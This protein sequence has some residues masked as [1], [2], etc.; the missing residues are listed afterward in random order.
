MLSSMPVIS[1][2]L[3]L[4]RRENR[5]IPRTQRPAAICSTS[6]IRTKATGRCWALLPS[7]RILVR[8]VAI[9]YP[10]CLIDDLLTG[11]I[12]AC[13]ELLTSLKSTSDVMSHGIQQNQGHEVCNVPWLPRCRLTT[14]VINLT[15]YYQNMMLRYCIALTNIIPI[16]CYDART[17]LNVISAVI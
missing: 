15:V 3:T 6:R 10:P 11:S 8:E 1:L 2:T 5:S 9:N 13:V 7:M 16:H 17:Q 4:Q 14:V 12:V